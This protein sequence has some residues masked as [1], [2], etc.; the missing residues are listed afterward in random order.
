MK[1]LK[2]LIILLCTVFMISGCNQ[3]NSAPKEN[4]T[5]LLLEVSKDDSAHKLYLFGSIHAADE[6][7]YPLPQYVI[8]AYNQSDVLAV[9]FDLIAYTN[10]LSNQ[11]TL[12]SKLM[13]EDDTIQNHLSAETYKTGIKILEEVGLYHS[14]MDYYQPIVWQ[15]LIENAVI[16]NSNL[17]EEYGIDKYF[18]TQAKENA[19]QIFELESAEYQYNLLLSFDESLQIHLLEESIN[20]YETSKEELNQLYELYKKGNQEALEKMLMEENENEYNKEYNEKLITLRNQNMAVSL[21]KL[22]SEEKTVFCTVGLAHIIGENGIAD[23]FIQKGY[24]IKKVY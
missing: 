9:E 20:N 17:N 10:D 19:K 15:S 22:F 14:I 8:D 13:Y 2:Y 3:G 4:S 16:I 23:L 12:L 18:L 6:S 11:F 1:K 21:E 5:P 24:K 7:I